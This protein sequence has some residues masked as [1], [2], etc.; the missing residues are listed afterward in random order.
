MCNSRPASILRVHVSQ[1]VDQFQV[2][3]QKLCFP[4]HAT[5]ESLGS[6]LLFLASSY[7]FVLFQST[8]TSVSLGRRE[9]LESA[10]AMFL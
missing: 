8:T 9:E 5:T 1:Q 6:F 10:A 4:V 2:R 7:Y 3:Y